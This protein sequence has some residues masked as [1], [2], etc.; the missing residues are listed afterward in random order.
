MKNSGT[1]EIIETE[2]VSISLE[3]TINIDAIKVNNDNGKI[4]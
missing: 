4:N 1:I 3:N 2:R